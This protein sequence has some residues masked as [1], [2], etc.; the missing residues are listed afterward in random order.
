MKEGAISGVGPLVII[1]ATDAKVPAYILLV[2]SM[3]EGADAGASSRAL[4]YLAKIYD[5]EIDTS[6]L[7]KEAKQQSKFADVEEEAGFGAGPSMYR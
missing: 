7:D 2:P 1:K 4:Q 3:V 5:M 6:E